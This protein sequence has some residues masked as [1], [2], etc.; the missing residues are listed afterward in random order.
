M[1]SIQFLAALAACAVLSAGLSAC[2]GGGGGDSDGSSGSGGQQTSSV[3]GGTTVTQVIA[4]PGAN[5]AVVTVAQAP[6]ATGTV[7]ANVPMVTVTLCAPGSTTQCTTI[8]NVMVDTGSSGFRVL[9][10]ALNASSLTS[11]STALTPVMAPSPHGTDPLGECMTFADGIAFGSVRSANLTIAGETASNVNIEVIGDPIAPQPTTTQTVS[12]SGATTINTALS[13]CKSS[14]NQNTTQTLHANAVLG[15]GTAVDD[16]SY[17]HSG[18]NATPMYYYCASASPYTCTN[19]A[20]TTLTSAQVVNNPVTFFPVDNN[21]VILELPPIASTGASS[22]TGVLVF[23]IDTESNNQLGGA[24]VLTATTATAQTTEGNITT[25][26][27]GQSLT[28]SFFDSGSNSMFFPSSIATCSDGIFYCPASTQSLSAVVSG[29]N[30][31]NEAIDFSVA[32][33]DTLT[34]S[35]NYA[36]NDQAGT[37]TYFGDNTTFD[38]GL[39]A[40]YGRNIYTGITG[41]TAGGYTGPFYAF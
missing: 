27:G 15:V 2:G 31:N 1:R 29:Q 17:C 26:Y 39:P 30:G 22:A 25:V 6:A 8:N 14:A 7:V 20:Q 34:A 13:E 9:A 3:L 18:T 41:K 38:W 12:G 4:S 28:T 37:T 35:G 24:T 19:L 11:W 33:V 21:G 40:F 5:A 36:F 32:N 23:G 16:C 10:S